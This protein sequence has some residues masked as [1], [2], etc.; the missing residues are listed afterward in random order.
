VDLDQLVANLSSYS[1]VTIVVQPDD[2]TERFW[3]FVS[4]TDNVTQQV[5]LVLP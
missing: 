2:Q 5:A 3:S 4:V 1:T